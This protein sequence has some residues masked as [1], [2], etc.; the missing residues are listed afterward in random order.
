MIPFDFSYKTWASGAP[1]F[2]GLEKQTVLAT[3]YWNSTLLP[4]GEHLDKQINV[5]T[6]I[7]NTYLTDDAGD[8]TVR[9]I[10]L[11]IQSKNKDNPM[12]LYFAPNAVHFPM[13]GKEEIRDP[14]VAELTSDIEKPSKLDAFTIEDIVEIIEELRSVLK[15][16]MT[17]GIFMQILNSDW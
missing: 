15:I 16:T 10:D 13:Q 6:K 3:D 4:T 17:L 1:D 12:F 7:G 2:C 14:I 9:T 5:T 11:H 8:A